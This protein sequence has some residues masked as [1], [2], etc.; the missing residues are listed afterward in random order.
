M[1]IA[2]GVIWFLFGLLYIWYKLLREDP[3]G[4]IV[5]TLLCVAVVA[6][7]ICFRVF[8]QW[9]LD[10]NLVIG[11]I[12]G[13]LF[14]VSLIA[15]GIKWAIEG[16]KEEE[17]RKERYNHIMDIINQET[18]TDD[19]L[20]W[21]AQKWKIRSHDGWKYYAWDFERVKP[22]IIEDYRRNVRFPEVAKQFWEGGGVDNRRGC[23]RGRT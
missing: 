7:L 1:G 20:F 12:F 2:S 9:L 18:Y 16:R 10:T 3:S 8:F 19:E 15:L 22:L 11:T 14:C 13:V 21:H 4:T 5:G 17:K 23:A 6:G